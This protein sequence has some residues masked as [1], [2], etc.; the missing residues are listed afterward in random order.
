MEKTT[1]IQKIENNTEIL[2]NILRTLSLL[3]KALD[4]LARNNYHN[5]NQYPD[6]LL[7]IESTL[8]LT[9]E[10]IQRFKAFCAV[11]AFIKLI[12]L[13]VSNIGILISEI[14]TEIHPENGKR[15]QK[16]KLAR[17]RTKKVLSNQ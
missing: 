10:W 5:R 1:D 2:I 14:I 7:E 3:E 16:K 4:R 6:L 8:V 11:P 13:C 17:Y 15:K 9:R 12:G